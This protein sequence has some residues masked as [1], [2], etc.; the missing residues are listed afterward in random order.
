MVSETAFTEQDRKS[1]A[2][3]LLRSEMAVPC[4]WIVREH[5]NPGFLLTV[6]ISP[7]SDGNLE[8]A[9]SCNRGTMDLTCPHALDVI[10]RIRA[11]AEIL[12]QLLRRDNS[13]AA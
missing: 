4:E 5:R 7:T 3:I 10:T 13:V 1:F 2:N 6:F 8:T 11:D 9:S 12:A